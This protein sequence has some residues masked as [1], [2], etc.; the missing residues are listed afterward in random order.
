VTYYT[1]LR[2]R[3]EIILFSET[4]LD[5]LFD[6]EL[7]LHT[8]SDFVEKL[9]LCDKCYGSIT[10]IICDDIDPDGYTNKYCPVLFHDLIKPAWK[11]EWINGF[12]MNKGL[13]E[14]HYKKRPLSGKLED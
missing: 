3:G 1:Y 11:L 8:R 2:K 4:L 10:H 14:R 12:W 6:E 13:S 5:G 9:G 7:L